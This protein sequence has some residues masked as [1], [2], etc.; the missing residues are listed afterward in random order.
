MANFLLLVMEYIIVRT[1]FFQSGLIFFVR[2]TL[3]EL[4]HLVDALE[5]FAKPTT[6]RI[7]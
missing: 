5:Q 3:K 1:E 6:S 4:S 2:N 7:R